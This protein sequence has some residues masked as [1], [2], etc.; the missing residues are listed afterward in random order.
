[1]W[2]HTPRLAPGCLLAGSLDANVD[3]SLRGAKAAVRVPEGRLRERLEVDAQVGC[4]REL[5]VGEG[6]ASH[7]KP[8]GIGWWIGPS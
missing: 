2:A 6:I 3:R 5:R 1:M 7:E 8:P 4:R